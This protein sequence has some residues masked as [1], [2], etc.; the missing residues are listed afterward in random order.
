VTRRAL[1]K[2]EIEEDD[3]RAY[4]ASSSDSDS[5]S[6]T[7]PGHRVKRDQL[8]AL[9][10]SGGDNLPEGWGQTTAK[11]NDSDDDVDMEVTFMPALSAKT[12]DETTLEKY[13]RKMREKRK[14]RKERNK[15]VDNEKEEKRETIVNDGFFG[16]SGESSGEEAST[17]VGKGK[18]KKN[19]RVADS[20]K[21]DRKSST[22]EEL[23]LLVAAD[24][25]RAEP[26]H[27]DM[28]AV[29]RSE[30]KKGKKDKRRKRGKNHEGEN[31]LQEKFAIDVKD[32]RFKAIHEDHTFAIDPSNPQCVYFFSQK[33]K[34]SYLIA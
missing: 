18:G 31:E 13:Q 30:K 25:A 32:D 27:F 10:L 29:I 11:A 24:D 28:K 17:V 22:K 33:K 1:T 5:G 34:H 20:G 4:I 12:E 9:L 3:L 16:E 14:M 8:R 19:G 15:E 26:R 7:K 21:T 6:G 2:K 23:D